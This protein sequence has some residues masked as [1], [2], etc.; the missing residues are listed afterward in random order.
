MDKELDEEERL[1]AVTLAN[2]RSILIVHKRAEQ[3]LVEAKEALQRKTDELVHSLALMRATLDS[4]TD[5]ILVLGE[6][7]QI[8]DF[9]KKM[10]EMWRI[11]P[12]IFSSRD[13]GRLRDFV[14]GVLKSPLPF[15]LGDLSNFGPTGTSQLLELKDGR[16]FEQFS[17]EQLIENRSTGRVLCFRDVTD[18]QQ[19]EEVVSRLAAVV[20]SSDDAI[21]SKT[22]DGIITSWN[23]GAERI[24]GYKAAETI[25]RPILLLIPSDLRKEEF[26]I[27]QRLKNGERIEH[28]ET[29]RLTKDGRTI[30]VSLSVSPVK[31][32]SGK[33]VGASKIARDITEDKRR[34][35]ALRE[36]E[37]RFRTLAD[38]AP[39]LI[40]EAG[41]DKLFNYFNQ[42]WLKFVGRSLEQETGKG[43]TEN[44]HPGDFDRCL[45]T[46]ASSFDAQTPFEMEYRIR[47]HTREYRWLLDR[48][49]PRFGP[50]G[51]F[52][53]YIGAC[54]DITESVQARQTSAERREE[55]ERMVGERTSSLQEAIAQMEEFSYSVSHDLRAPLRAMQGYANALLEDYRGKIIDKEGEE[56]LQRIVCSGIRMDR[57][58]RDVLV[59]S[60]IPRTGDA[61][62]GRRP[63]QVDFRHHPAVSRGQDKRCGNIARKTAVI[64]RGERIVSRPGHFQSGG[65]C[66]QILPPRPTPA[67]AD[68]DGAAAKSGSIMGGG[69][70]NRDSSG[71]PG[72]HLGYVR[73]GAPPAYVRRHRNRIGDR[74]K[75][76]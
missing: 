41:T 24:F 72:A 35:E 17:Q 64:R 10:I 7:G 29:V 61:V 27:I 46:F 12:E 55:L 43:W 15:V 65:Q 4:T 3:E 68:L 67:T 47:H 20:E 11:P 76:N 45:R 18:R 28:Y 2:A 14:S 25:G 59:Y 6:D 74:P 9:N 37:V 44:I 34:Q 58:T 1:R 26:G 33:V 63:G 31:D 51:T 54:V 70:W 42:T 40:W 66:G 36:S 13:I 53:G 49:T 56:Y 50:Q 16:L 52:Q 69:Q 39:L 32:G 21:I 5:G 73:A 57:L 19:K 62:A 23:S 71:A 30:N 75:N 38:A 60:R 8:A 22:L 48:G